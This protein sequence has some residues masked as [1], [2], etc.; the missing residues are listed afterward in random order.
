MIDALLAK[1]QREEDGRVVEAVSLQ[2]HSQAVLAAADVIFD[3]VKY[4]LPDATDRS[5]LQ[6]LIRAGAV[7]HDLGKANNIFQGKVLPE[8]PEFPKIKWTERQPLRHEGLSALIVAGYINEAREFSEHLE[9]NLFNDWEDTQKALWMLAWLVGGHHLQMHHAEDDSSGIV[10]ISGIPPDN[11]RFHG[12]LLGEKWQKT[13]S[14]ILCE[15]PYVPDFTISTDITEGDKHHAAL[16][17]NFSWESEHQAESL[18]PDD[19]RLLAFSKALLIAAD[20]AGSALW[21]GKGDEENR[22]KNGIRLSLQNHCKQA[23]L[24]K[25]VCSRLNVDENTDYESKLHPFQRRVKNAR[26]TRVVLQAACGGGKTIAA[27]EWARQHVKTGRKL[28]FTYPTTGTAAAG[29]NDY[30]FIQEDLERALITSRADVDIRQMLANKPPASA[31]KD[32]GLRHP[33]RNQ[34]LENLMKQESLQA[35]GQQAVAATADFVLGLM[36]NHRRGLFS[37]PA[38]VKSAIVFD[39][40]HNYDARM[41]GSLLR[42]LRALPDVPALLMTA[43]L[44]PARREALAAAGIEYTLIEGDDEVENA[45]RYR[46]QWHEINEEAA[47]WQ[48]VNNALNDDNKV[49]WVCNTVADAVRVFREAKKQNGTVE[50]L[51]FHS[52]FCYGHRVQRQKEVL[53]AFNKKQTPCLA[54]T[55]QVC[56]MSLDISAGLLVSALAPLPALVQ[57]LGRL[58]RRLEN[59]DGARCLIYDYN[60]R[61]GRPY[62]HIELE[63]ARDAVE[64]LTERDLSQRDLK[65]ALDEIQEDVKDIKFYSAWL[66]GGWESRQAPL[67]EG[68]ATLP[69]L[70]EQHKNEIGTSIQEMGRS[71]AVK[72]WLV[73]VLHDRKSVRVIRKIGGYPLVSGVEYDDQTG[74]G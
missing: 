73:P 47:C 53:A 61:D 40:I 54:V 23:D 36:Q 46:L 56:E 31:D 69:V 64:R 34:E 7:L 13:F 55:T 38:I 52:R 17:E 39:E 9:K 25:L 8:R 28:I 16:V 15:A 41:F 62:R 10:R 65:N 48:A 4:F 59:P 60:G 1:S 19:M 29:F 14:E 57:R 45:A 70:L 2:E 43:S 24:T 3:E 6:Q 12:E 22:M 72:N 71:L 37:F 49:L 58:N 42:F 35:W 11:I 50:P 27:Y 67:R 18:A 30:L 44:T 5:R 51:L 20:I 74:A 63:A 21:D 32:G 26:A 66:D 33:N 68:D